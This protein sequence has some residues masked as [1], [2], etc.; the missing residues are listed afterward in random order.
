MAELELQCRLKCPFSIAFGVVLNAAEGLFLTS[1][2]CSC[3]GIKCNVCSLSQARVIELSDF[4]SA[5]L[6]GLS[7]KEQDCTTCFYAPS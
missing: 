4:T 3:D 1:I 7:V 6:A 5:D 2:T